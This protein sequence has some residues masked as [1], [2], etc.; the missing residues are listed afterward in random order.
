VEVR[1]G[2]TQ[3]ATGRLG[4]T[5]IDPS[6]KLIVETILNGLKEEIKKQITATFSNT[7]VFIDVS[8]TAVS[9][10][11]FYNSIKGI[12]INTNSKGQIGNYEYANPEEFDLPIIIQKVE[13]TI[14][15]EIQILKET[16]RKYAGIPT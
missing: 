11:W 15:K 2:V 1:S 9:I 5:M 10:L 4:G 7:A 14:Q 6:F 16:D 3:H 13:E 12:H 8:G